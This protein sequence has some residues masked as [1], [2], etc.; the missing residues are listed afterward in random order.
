M[1][2]KHESGNST[3]PLRVFFN[4]RASRATTSRSELI[5]DLTALRC[6]RLLLAEFYHERASK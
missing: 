1:R 2:R 4:C 5:R 6:A 3:L